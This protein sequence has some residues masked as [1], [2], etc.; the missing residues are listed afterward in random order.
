MVGACGG[1]ERQP[2]LTRWP[3]VARESSV[4]LGDS[5]QGAPATLAGRPGPPGW[6]ARATLAGQGCPARAVRLGT[7][8]HT[9]SG[10]PA[11]LAGSHQPY[12]L[13][14]AGQAGWRPP[15]LVGHIRTLAIYVRSLPTWLKLPAF[16]TRKCVPRAT[17]RK[18]LPLRG[19]SD[20]LPL[21]ERTFPSAVGG[22]RRPEP[23]KPPK[24]VCEGR[25]LGCGA[26]SVT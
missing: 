17:N 18:N 1:S 11:P 9:G 2:W 5:E 12:R 7:A 21:P 20:R 8:S 19:P 3:R 14:G 13:V 22:R 6:A 24:Q 16:L 25:D 15:R 4:L 23:S 26:P 10:D